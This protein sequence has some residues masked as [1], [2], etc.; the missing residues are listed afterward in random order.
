MKIVNGQL[1]QSQPQRVSND[2]NAELTA[3]YVGVA[4]VKVARLQF[5]LALSQLVVLKASLELPD[6]RLVAKY[7]EADQ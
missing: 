5:S 4:I 3:D 7:S 6:V 1:S 2:C